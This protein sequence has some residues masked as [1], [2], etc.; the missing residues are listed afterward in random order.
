M[1][2]RQEQALEEKKVRG[3]TGTRQLGA[4]HKFPSPLSPLKCL[5]CPFEY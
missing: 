4:D 5:K 2:A 3:P 1:I